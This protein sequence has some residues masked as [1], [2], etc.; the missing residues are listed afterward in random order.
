MSLWD[1]GVLSFWS[2]PGNFL[3][4]DNTFSIDRMLFTRLIVLLLI[5]SYTSAEKSKRILLN[6]PHIYD[7]LQNKVAALEQELMA[8]KSKY[9][10]L[11]DPIK[12]FPWAHKNKDFESLFF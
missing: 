12:S 3:S 7:N 1:C 2:C 10:F 4:E 5:L 11:G 6:D 8:L 9:F